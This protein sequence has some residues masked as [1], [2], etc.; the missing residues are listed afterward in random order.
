MCGVYLE[1]FGALDSEGGGAATQIPIQTLVSL[2][3]STAS[4]RKTHAQQLHFVPLMCICRLLPVVL[5]AVQLDGRA[6]ASEFINLCRPEEDMVTRSGARELS[7]VGLRAGLL[8]L[9]GI[10]P[11]KLA[12]TEQEQLPTLLTLNLKAYTCLN[13][14]EPIFCRFLI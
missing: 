1:S 9:L 7:L 5:C 4:Q 12:H 10:F 8:L 13:Q 11:D 3:P 6:S 14:P 2:C